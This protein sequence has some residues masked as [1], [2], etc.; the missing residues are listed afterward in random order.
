M[1]VRLSFSAWYWKLTLKILAP[2]IIIC[3]VTLTL[4]NITPCYYGDYVYPDY[5]QVIITTLCSDSTHDTQGW[6][7][8][9]AMLPFLPIPVC[10]V[11]QACQ[12]GGLLDTRQWSR[13]KI[14]AT[15]D[16]TSSNTE[17]DV[18]HTNKDEV[19]K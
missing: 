16:K 8:A 14:R 2:V 12:G 5:V 9:M 6:G 1:G 17:T 15:T 10:L 11:V 3:I 7:W 13:Q 19:Q 18:V 4:I